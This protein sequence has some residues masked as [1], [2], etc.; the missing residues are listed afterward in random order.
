MPM[1]G[2]PGQKSYKTDQ[3][4]PLFIKIVCFQNI[5]AQRPPLYESKPTKLKTK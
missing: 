3:F 1:D 4:C 2:N 5:Q